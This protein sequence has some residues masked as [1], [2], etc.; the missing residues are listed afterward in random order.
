MSVWVE[1]LTALPA[2]AAEAAAGLG[3]TRL[4]QRLRTARGDDDPLV[5]DLEAVARDEKVDLA[6]LVKFLRGEGHE[7]VLSTGDLGT[8]A[9]SQQVGINRGTVVQGVHIEAPTNPGAL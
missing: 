9:S 5:R 6:R 4:L 8:N 1:L 7:I 2:G 3:L